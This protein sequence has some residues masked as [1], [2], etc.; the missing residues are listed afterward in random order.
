[1]EL[2][3]NDWPEPF[4]SRG[5]GQEWIDQCAVCGKKID[6]AQNIAAYVKSAASG[7]HVVGMF[8][9]GA[10]LDLR[11]FEPN[12][13]QV[14]IGVCDDHLP[15]LE[16]LDQITHANGNV[17]TRKMVAEAGFPVRPSADDAIR[18]I[19]GYINDNATY[20]YKAEVLAGVRGQLANI[21]NIEA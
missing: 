7:R 9:Q 11:K 21:L 14:K 10:R 2:E 6:L 20:P 18:G 16:A 12:Y 1:M 3:P 5:I 8:A 17:I 15:Q 13:I 19:I 4:A